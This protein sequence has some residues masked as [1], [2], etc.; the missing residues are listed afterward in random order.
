[1]NDWISVKDHYPVG[2]MEVLAI[3]RFGFQ[4]I[5]RYAGK[6]YRGVDQWKMKTERTERCV[7]GRVT[8]WMRKPVDPAWG[9]E[10]DLSS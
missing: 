9:H 2:D 4:F 3:T 10:N 1:M 8:H 5:G 7:A 6:D